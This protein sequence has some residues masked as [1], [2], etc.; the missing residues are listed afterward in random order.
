METIGGILADDMG[1]GKTL[2]V[3]ATVIR[4]TEAGRLFE[5][6]DAI[7]A[8]SSGMESISSMIFSRATWLLYPRL[9]CSRSV[10]CQ[11]LS[12]SQIFAVVA[13]SSSHN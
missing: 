1:L 5:K 3:L 7:E 13:E 2:A 8:R 9:V 11:I 4:S 12:T 10:E 6:T